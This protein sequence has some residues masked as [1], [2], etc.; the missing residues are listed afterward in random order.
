MGQVVGEAQG[1]TGKGVSCRE[2]G[3]SIDV[4][5][6]IARP[7]CSDTNWHTM[8]YLIRCAFAS[9]AGSS[10]AY[11]ATAVGA[12]PPPSE[13]GLGLLARTRAFFRELASSAAGG[14]ER[15]FLL[16]TLE[17]A[18]EARAR[19]WDQGERDR[20][21]GGRG[22]AE[23]QTKLTRGRLDGGAVEKLGSLV[24]EYFEQ[25]G[26]KMCC[27]DDLHP[28]LEVL[29]EEERTTLRETM[30]DVANGVMDGVSCRPRKFD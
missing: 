30:D 27:F 15:G 10:A 20:R 5:N 8:L 25:F 17:I 9:A 16:G 6:A 22:Q 13:A 2:Q 14:K 4:L 29:T 1:R 3:V 26:T 11:D 24:E 18:R 28:Y 7:S 23:D 21:P 12:L 19:G